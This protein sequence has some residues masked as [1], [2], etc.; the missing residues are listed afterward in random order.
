MTGKKSTKK[1]PKQMA[2]AILTPLDSQGNRNSK[3]SVFIRLLLMC[4]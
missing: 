2:E 1:T 3:E 4:V